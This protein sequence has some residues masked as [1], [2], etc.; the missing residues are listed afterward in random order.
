MLGL[1]QRQ[2]PAQR[3][4]SFCLR[5]LVSSTFCRLPE[6]WQTCPI[7]FYPRLAPALFS[8]TRPC[9]GTRT[10][11]PAAAHTLHSLIYPLLSPPRSIFPQPPHHVGKRIIAALSREHCWSG[12]RHNGSQ[13]EYAFSPSSFS[14]SDTPPPAGFPSRLLSRRAPALPASFG[15]L[16]WAPITNS[17]AGKAQIEC[18][19]DDALIHLKSYKYSSVDKSPVSKYILGPWVRHSI[20][21]QAAP[22]LRP[23][24]NRGPPV[25]LVVSHI[26]PPAQY[27]E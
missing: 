5:M 16:T 8:S 14:S 18:I 4:D 27:M 11:T 9:S 6:L 19:S 3:I 24:S 22:V 10:H 26:N 23:R 15:L 20:C 1:A 25:R 2:N 7:S 17:L 12:P 21:Y 13:Y